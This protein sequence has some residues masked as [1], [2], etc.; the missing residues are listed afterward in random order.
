[1][2]PPGECSPPRP[3]P[4]R[5]GFRLSTRSSQWLLSWPRSSG[6]NAGSGH[7]PKHQNRLEPL[8]IMRDRQA[9]S[10]SHDSSSIHFPLSDAKP[11]GRHG[12]RLQRRQSA[13]ILFFA[14]AVFSALAVLI[15]RERSGWGLVA[16]VLAIGMA[17]FGWPFGTMSIGP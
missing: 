8:P 1:M 10:N 5:R 7:R 12:S 11:P 17:I 6:R 13:L 4:R 15:L 9:S 2:P 3:R 14:A 16:A